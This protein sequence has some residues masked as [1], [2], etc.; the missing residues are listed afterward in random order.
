MIMP[1]FFPCG[2]PFARLVPITGGKPAP[3]R[4]AGDAKSPGDSQTPGPRT[5]SCRQK[6]VFTNAN[7]LEGQHLIHRL[8]PI[9][10]MS[11]LYFKWAYMRLMEFIHNMTVTITTATFD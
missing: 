3:I 2:R 11:S 5:N 4:R 1:D 7:A 6:A 10:R 8:S 9:I